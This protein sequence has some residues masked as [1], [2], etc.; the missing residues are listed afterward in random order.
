VDRCIA[1]DLETVR[2]PPWQKG[3]AAGTERPGLIPAHKADVTVER[4]KLLVFG[5]LQVVG[6]G[7]TRTEHLLDQAE[8]TAS[9]G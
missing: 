6:R 8:D 2:D 9:L 1:R 4:V 7:C 5:M 3:D